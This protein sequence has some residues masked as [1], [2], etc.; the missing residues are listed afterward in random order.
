MCISDWCHFQKQDKILGRKVNKCA[1]QF[2]I[3]Q[4]TK[5]SENLV[6]LLILLMYCR[7]SLV[8]NYLSFNFL[9]GASIKI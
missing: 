8:Q 2:L 6:G 1:F 9:R 7:L 3:E 5:F 4:D